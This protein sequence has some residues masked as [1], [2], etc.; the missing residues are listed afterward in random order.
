MQQ[1][2]DIPVTKLLPSQTSQEDDVG[3]MLSEFAKALEAVDPEN[4]LAKLNKT[5]ISDN[6]GGRIRL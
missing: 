3:L 5:S 1:S 2:P 4:P 6:N